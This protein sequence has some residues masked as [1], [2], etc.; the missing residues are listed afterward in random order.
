MLLKLALAVSGYTARWLRTT[1]RCF[2]S[3]AEAG[4]V[5]AVIDFH[6]HTRGGHFGPWLKWFV[7]EFAKRFSLV[8]VVT[9][10]PVATAALFEA[11]PEECRS[12]VVFQKL[13]PSL[14]KRFDLDLLDV[15][16]EARGVRL[17]A[18]IMWG[19]DLLDLATTKRPSAIPWATFCGVSWFLRGYDTV[20]AAAEA[21]V[22]ERLKASP[23]C[24]GFLQADRYV[25]DNDKR[26]I[27]VPD[28]ENVALPPP[29]DKPCSVAAIE[30]HRGATF[31]VGCFGLL[32]GPR[33]LNELL[34]LSQRHRDV[35]FVIAGKIFVDS[36]DEALRP[37]LGNGA[38]ENIL[39]LPGFIEDNRELNAVINAVDAVFIDG[40]N[41]PVQ[42]TIVCRAVHFGKCIVT[43][44]SNSWTADFIRDAGVGVEYDSCDDDLPARWSGWLQSGGAERSRCASAKT[45]DPEAM[46]ACFDSITNRLLCRGAEPCMTVE[47]RA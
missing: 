26:A 11:G 15:I 16:P 3:R 9:P 47:T 46:T 38:T 8:L 32:T 22:L 44:R 31:S 4:E 6:E 1:R 14:G 27:W 21:Q 40:R 24:R 23:S 20:A 33:C 17:H 41:Y 35:R 2:P 30:R 36:V 29:G 19:Q 28:L 7:D 43:P 10:H 12:N 13:P 37:L 34:R 5:L 45:R 42:S 18:F 39:V 25:A